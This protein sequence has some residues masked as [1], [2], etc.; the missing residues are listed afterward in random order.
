[1]PFKKYWNT[2]KETRVSCETRGGQTFFLYGRKYP[3][4]VFENTHE[5]IMYGYGG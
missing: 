1:M 3:L 4:K 2:H 5:S